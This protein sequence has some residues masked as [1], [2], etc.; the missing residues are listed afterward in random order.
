MIWEDSAGSRNA[1]YAVPHSEID[2]VCRRSA[3]L[4]SHKY[5]E[6]TIAY[7]AGSALKGKNMPSTL[8]S[9]KV[10][11][12][13]SLYAFFCLLLVGFFLAFSYVISK[14]ADAAGAPLLTFLMAA[15]VG[16]GT[17]LFTISALLREPMLFNQRSFEYALLSSRFLTPWPFLRLDMSVQDLFR[18]A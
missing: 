1:I 6:K 14:L 3:T 11:G 9:K 2:D 4:T 5:R 15:M 17:I 18:S 12:Q 10:T 7:P 8:D 13:S 16:A